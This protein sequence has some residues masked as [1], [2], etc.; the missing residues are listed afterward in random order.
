MLNI[1]ESEKTHVQCAQGE[2]FLHVSHVL[3]VYILEKFDSCKFFDDEIQTSMFYPTLHD[4]MLHVLEE[5]SDRRIRK[6]MMVRKTNVFI[7]F[8][9]FFKTWLL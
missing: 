7:L 3:T 6:D 8:F 4:V 5:N 2:Y 9:S 1:L